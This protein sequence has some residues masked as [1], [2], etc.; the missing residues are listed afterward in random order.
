MSKKTEPATAPEL[1]FSGADWDFNTLKAT[2]DA[3]EDIAINDLKLD[4]YPNQVEV[5]TSEQM[6]DAY[7][8]I[9][10]PL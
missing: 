5:I 10:M 2:Y 1:L 9:G 7:S 8:S 3:I 4:V 6:L